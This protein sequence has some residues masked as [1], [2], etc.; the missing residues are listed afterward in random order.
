M[1]EAI[2]AMIWLDPPDLPRF[3]LGPPGQGDREEGRQ[4]EGRR[5][6]NRA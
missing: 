3:D 5:G 2:T 1:N 4:K 6:R